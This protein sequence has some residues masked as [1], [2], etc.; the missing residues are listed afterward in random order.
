MVGDDESEHGV[1]QELEALVRRVAASLGTPGPVRDRLDEKRRIVEGAAQTGHQLDQR[2]VQG[3]AGI[4][5]GAIAF[6][7]APS[8]ATT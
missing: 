4:Q 8:L 2:G 5:S 1:A 3:P 6:Q 7:A